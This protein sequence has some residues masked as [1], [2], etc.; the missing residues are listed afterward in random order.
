M[1]TDLVERGDCPCG[2]GEFVVYRET[3]DHGWPTRNWSRRFGEL[4]C[5]D[6]E[7]EYVVQG[8]KLVRRADHEAQRR[9]TEERRRQEDE[10]MESPR[11]K[12]IF[13]RL[14]NLLDHQQSI[15]AT[16]RL[17]SRYNLVSISEGTFRKHWRGGEDWVRQQSGFLLLNQL[18]KTGVINEEKDA[19]LVDEFK[20]LNTPRPCASHRTAP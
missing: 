1:S 2:K 11:L 13:A 7:A 14:A 18:V 10:L 19:A 5:T 17:L 8:L 6:C 12:D 16:W 3:P 20:R 9:E 15:A 4:Q